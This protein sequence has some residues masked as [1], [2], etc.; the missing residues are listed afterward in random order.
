MRAGRAMGALHATRRRARALACTRAA[1]CVVRSER[2]RSAARWRARKNSARPHVLRRLHC[3]LSKL[4]LLERACCGAAIGRVECANTQWSR[5]FRAF[6]RTPSLTH[7][8]VSAT[9]R[10][11]GG[12]DHSQS[13]APPR[14]PH[15]REAGR[16]AAHRPP[17]R[18]WHQRLRSRC[19]AVPYPAHTASRDNTEET[20]GICK[21]CPQSLVPR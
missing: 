18:I 12:F 13:L 21:R 2:A 5:K 17:P 16:A 20:P 4:Q 11:E 1:T 19:T 6:W 10:S 14:E 8:S 7:I 3:D 15:A 9:I